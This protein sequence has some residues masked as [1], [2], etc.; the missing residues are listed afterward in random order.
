MKTRWAM[1]AAGLWAIAACQPAPM[2]DSAADPLRGVGF[3]DYESYLAERQAR[4]AQLVGLAPSS[5]RDTGAPAATGGMPGLTAANLAAAGIGV[6]GTV[7]RPA[8]PG[9][10]SPAAR[11][12]AAARA[13]AAPLAAPGIAAGVGT[14]AQEQVITPAAGSRAAG[15]SDEQDFAAVSSRETIQSDAAR[16][17]QQRA[18]RVEVSPA[19]LPQPSEA[20]GPDIVAYALRTTNAVGEPLYRRVL[21]SEGRAARQCARFAGAD[22]AQ[23]AFLEAG[24]P[25]RDRMGLDPDGDGFAC[26][27]S[28]APF[29]AARG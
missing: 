3:G 16:L 2:A 1:A 11:P 24:G 26:D 23:R 13:P 8:A 15:L 4:E 29:R 10:A 28:P 20:R 12:A 21:A 7:S 19:Q 17:E 5:P 6:N 27:W 18:S 25:W 14:P 9:T 22:L